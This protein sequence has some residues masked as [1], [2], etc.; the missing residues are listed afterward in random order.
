M[1]KILFTLTLCAAANIFIIFAQT[2]PQ[3]NKNN[4]QDNSIVVPESLNG[5]LATLLHEWQIDFSK[6]DNKCKQG[7]NVMFHDSVYTKR[8]YDI[9]TEMELSFNQVVKQYIDM[10]A[11]R[12]RDIV[13]YMLTIGEYYFAMFEEVLDK[14]GLPLELKYLPVI[15]SALNPVAVS[16]LEQQG[17]GNLCSERDEAT[18]FR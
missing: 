4:I 5:H 3:Q 9:P 14:Y 16:E 10:Y 18:G 12:R 13:G 11:N 8:L 2:N 1:K 17:Y 6:S 15:E 7:A